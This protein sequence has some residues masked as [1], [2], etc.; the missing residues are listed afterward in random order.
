[1][2]MNKNAMNRQVFSLPELIKTQ[3]ED[4][5]P[6]T[7]KVLSTP[8][9]FSIQKI[10]LVGCGDSY[11]AALATKHVFEKLTKMPVEVVTA[12]ELSR[13]YPQNQLGFAPLNPLVIAVSN[14][15]EGARVGEAVQRAVKHNAF[16]LGITGNSASVLGRHA[17]RVLPLHIPPFVSAPGIRSYV[18]SLIALLLLA[19]RLGE[20][21]GNIT[22]DHANLLRGDILSQGK[23]LESMLPLMD[24]KMNL[25]SEG[26]K[27]LEAW[28]FVGAGSDYASAWYG[29]AK[30]FEATGQYAMHIN[31]EEWLHL[32]FFMRN[33]SKIATVVFA[34]LKNP[35]ISRTKEMIGYAKE[36][37][38]PLL[39]IS[40]GEAADFSIPEENIVQFPAS[41]YDESVSIAQIAPIALLAGS[42]M[43]LLGEVDGRGCEGLWSFCQNGAS[44]KK[45]EI[46]LL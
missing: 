13:F 12:I 34:N 6:S 11:A 44:V 9:I 22:M 46:I 36:L 31:S 24:S 16:V 7:R 8:E 28:D 17:S 43:T 45:S 20:V 39:V 29:H 35:A 25:L 21:R 4:L 30:I 23:R 19:I 14:S 26:W 27:M 1:M 41:A 3:F 40:D 2:N 18:V 15:G 32:N 10:V 33:T 37:K 38:R 5:E 42:V